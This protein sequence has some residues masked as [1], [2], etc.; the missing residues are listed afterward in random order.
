MKILQKV[1]SVLDRLKVILHIQLSDEL[2]LQTTHSQLIQKGF[3][4]EFRL[5]LDRICKSIRYEIDQSDNL[6]ILEGLSGIQLK[7]GFYQKYASRTLFSQTFKKAI[8]YSLTFNV[9]VWFPIDKE[10][11][12]EL[13]KIGLRFNDPICTLLLF[14]FNLAISLS[15]FRKLITIRKNVIEEAREHSSITRPKMK[16]GDEAV[17][18]HLFSLFNFPNIDNSDLTLF[19]WLKNRLGVS[20]LFLDD[21][22]TLPSLN[23]QKIGSAYRSSVIPSNSC[24]FKLSFYLG[25]ISRV[26]FFL[27]TLKINFWHLSTQVDQVYISRLLA[28][29]QTKIDVKRVF[30]PSTVIV[31]KP[32]WANVMEYAGKEIIL[33]NYTAM[34]EPQDPELNRIVDGIWRLTN[35]KFAWVVDDIQIMQMQQAS[36]TD[37]TKCLIVGVPWWSGQKFE[38]PIVLEKPFIAAFDTHIQSDLLFSAGIVDDLGWNNPLLES[39]FM[40]TILDVATNLGFLVVHK[41]KRRVAGKKQ[42][43]LDI[44]IRKLR[45]KYG[46]SYLYVDE[47]VSAESIISSAKAVVSKPISTTAFVA[48]QFN[49]PS[50]ILDLT[51]NI[52]RN[53]PGLRN[54][55]LVYDSSELYSCLKEATLK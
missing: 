41:R 31:S 39:I 43:E 17:F 50:I 25:Y 30:I 12:I 2:P 49:I 4:R 34:A 28:M 21:C 19:S 36:G 1:R 33:L 51:K 9:P 8:S 23:R 14:S 45:E 52:K 44:L 47:D 54:C 11:R 10:S 48:L 42:Y 22:S 20:T 38:S 3:Y 18:L 16:K 29:N 40:T 24:R 5:A 7:L 46:D 15:A 27:F 6:F 53:D 35:W 13:R 26:I 37:E 55:K 32:L